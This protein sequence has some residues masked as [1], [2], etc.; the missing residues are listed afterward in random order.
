MWKG[1]SPLV[2]LGKE[3]VEKYVDKAKQKNIKSYN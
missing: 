3:P 1:L 2:K